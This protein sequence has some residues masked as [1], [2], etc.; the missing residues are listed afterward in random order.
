LH[1]GEK[2]ESVAGCGNMTTANYVK[3]PDPGERITLLGD[4]KTIRMKGESK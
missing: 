4:G 1:L 2:L 3:G